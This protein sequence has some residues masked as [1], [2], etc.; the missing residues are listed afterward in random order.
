MLKHSPEHRHRQ[1]TLALFTTLW[2]FFLWIL[3]AQQ[4]Q[5]FVC[6]WPCQPYYA[7]ATGHDDDGYST[8]D[9]V[10][11]QYHT[12]IE[13]TKAKVVLKP[14]LNSLLLPRCVCFS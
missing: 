10:L 1:A 4:S 12:S 8:L 14:G 3:A 6:C 7:R 9:P 13:F 2:R 5:S 11:Y